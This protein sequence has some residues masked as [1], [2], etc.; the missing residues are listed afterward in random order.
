M[1]TTTAVAQGVTVDVAGGKN[2]VL[3]DNV[4]A[5]PTQLTVSAIAAMLP[6]FA[7]TTPLSTIFNPLPYVIAF[8]RCRDPLPDQRFELM[9]L[10]RCEG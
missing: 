5:D 9:N 4:D 10:F 6:E 2:V 3:V 1:T 8:L 7:P